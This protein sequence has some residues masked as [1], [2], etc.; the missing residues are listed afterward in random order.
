[1]LEP[2]VPRYR[3]DR[4]TW[5]A[6]QA[7]GAQ[8]FWEICAPA[9]LSKCPHIRKGKVGK[10]D[11]KIA[12]GLEAAPCCIG[13]AGHIAAACWQEETGLHRP[14]LAATLWVRRKIGKM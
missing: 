13:P 12:A 2:T 4:A 1:M 9:P 7:K 11:N 14:L 6:K 10:N 3:C 8:G 5:P